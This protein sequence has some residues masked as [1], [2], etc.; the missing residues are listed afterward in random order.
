M[1]IT[2]NAIVRFCLFDWHHWTELNL[3]KDLAWCKLFYKESC[4]NSSTIV[5]LTV[6]HSMNDNKK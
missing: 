5:T 4:D 1:T 3:D 6:V 2:T